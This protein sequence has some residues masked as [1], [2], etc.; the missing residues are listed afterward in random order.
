MSF[1]MLRTMLNVIELN[2]SIGIDKISNL[3]VG[4]P[5]NGQKKPLDRQGRQSKGEGFF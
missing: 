1:G 2:S 5:L 3:S 4:V